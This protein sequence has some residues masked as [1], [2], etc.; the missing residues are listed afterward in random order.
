M[1]LNCAFCLKCECNWLRA[2]RSKLETVPQSGQALFI[3]SVSGERQINFLELIEHL[4]RVVGL[5]VSAI[6]GLITIAKS[7]QRL[8][9]QQTAIWKAIFIEIMGVVWIHVALLLAI[10][11]IVLWN[12]HSQ[13][14]WPII[15]LVLGILATLW[16]G[17]EG[18]FDLRSKLQVPGWLDNLLFSCL[19]LGGAIVIISEVNVAVRKELLSCEFRFEGTLSGAVEA[20]DARCVD[21]WLQQDPPPA[22]VGNPPLLYVAA[23]GD[24]AL[25]LASLLDSGRFDPNMPT[26]AGDTPLH[27]AVQN[28]RHDMV[29]RLLSHGAS[30]NL[31]NRKN[32]T[33]FE[34]AAKGEDKSLGD[35]FKGNVCWHPSVA[36]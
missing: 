13:P 36:P 12:M 11:G 23:G 20:G 31:P 21:H 17:L 18:L 29:Y 4:P 2:G 22:G 35:L 3:N 7:I 15:G 14:V 5:I 1:V 32:I 16:L 24:N 25:V 28:G 30:M 33:P 9:E 10:W 34:L 19:I 8:N 26:A 6:V 27:I